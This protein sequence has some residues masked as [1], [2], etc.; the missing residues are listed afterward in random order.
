MEHW[1][2][3]HR[4]VIALIHPKL[5]ARVET[6]RS[7]FLQREIPG[8]ERAEYNPSAASGALRAASRE[9]RRTRQRTAD[10]SA[11]PFGD[12]TKS[13]SAPD[14][15]IRTAVASCACSSQC[16]AAAIRLKNTWC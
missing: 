12:S 5:F 1:C 7:A 9:T 3:P 13:D 15:N 2:Q 14:Q 4:E 10:H 16:W 8:S 11:G 6:R